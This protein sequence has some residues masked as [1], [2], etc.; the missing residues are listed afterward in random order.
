LLLTGGLSPIVFVRVRVGNGS[1]EISNL[2]EKIADFNQNVVC[3]A[4]ISVASRLEIVCLEWLRDL[5]QLPPPFGGVLVTGGTMAN[6]TAQPVAPV[7]R[8]QASVQL[9]VVIVAR[10]GTRFPVSNGTARR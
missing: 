9:R 7:F 3:H 5:F 1:H 8:H 10:R 6:F 4:G 2:C